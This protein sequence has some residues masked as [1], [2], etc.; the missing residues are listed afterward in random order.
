MT[1]VCGCVICTKLSSGYKQ[2]KRDRERW[3]DKEIERDRMRKG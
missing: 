2:K 3:R 1:S